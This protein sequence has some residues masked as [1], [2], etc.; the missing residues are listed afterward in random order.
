MGA[1]L[2]QNMGKTWRPATWAEMTKSFPNQVSVDAAES[3][4][5]KSDNDQKRKATEAAKE[6]RRRSKYTKITA[7]RKA[8]T[9]S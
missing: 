3:S 1:G 8:Y 6:Q 2:Q 7:A 9:R 4:A 5:K